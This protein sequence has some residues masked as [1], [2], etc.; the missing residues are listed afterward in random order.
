VMTSTTN[1]IQLQMDLNDHIKGG[2]E[3]WNT[4]N[5]TRIITKETVDYWDM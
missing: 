3:F 2:Y 4:W 1:L 5:G